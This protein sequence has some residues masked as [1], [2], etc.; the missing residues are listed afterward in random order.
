MIDHQRCSGLSI[1]T[2]GNRIYLELEAELRTHQP[3]AK[4]LFFGHVVALAGQLLPFVVQLISLKIRGVVYDSS[5]QHLDCIQVESLDK[6]CQPMLIGR[7][8]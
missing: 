7:C 8:S 6:I 5:D 2:R 3:E 1:P 4:N